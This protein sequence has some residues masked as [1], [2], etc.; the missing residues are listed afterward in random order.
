MSVIMTLKR[1]HFNARS[2]IAIIIIKAFRNYYAR[3]V[4]NSSKNVVASKSK[5]T[6]QNGK[7]TEIT[8]KYQQYKCQIKIDIFIQYII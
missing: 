1:H 8:K 2:I 5:F 6:V 7:N 4:I 3:L